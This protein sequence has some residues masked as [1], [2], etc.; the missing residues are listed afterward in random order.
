MQQALME[1]AYGSGIC[2]GLGASLGANNLAPDGSAS[3]EQ[4][5]HIKIFSI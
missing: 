2:A 3:F 5:R 1:G 4:K